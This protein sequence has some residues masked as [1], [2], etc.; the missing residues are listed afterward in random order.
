MVS[1]DL[2][3][4]HRAH[5]RNHDRNLIKNTTFNNFWRRF[6]VRSR[7]SSRHPSSGLCSFSLLPLSLRLLVLERSRTD[8]HGP[9]DGRDRL[10]DLRQLPESSLCSL[11]LLSSL[12][13]FVSG[14][15]GRDSSS[16]N[17][18]NDKNFVQNASWSRVREGR[19]ENA[20]RR[21]EDEAR[22][23]S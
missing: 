13:L 2:T 12:S 6:L 8:A 22:S 7:A 17:V 14:A 15:R 21:R 4:F 5:D 16:P 20:T 23:K 1:T 9:R 18:E 11:V 10:Q 3:R 19:E